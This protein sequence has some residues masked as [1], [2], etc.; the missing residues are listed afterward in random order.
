MI[1]NKAKTIFFI[2]KPLSDILHII[3]L[4]IYIQQGGTKLNKVE[5]A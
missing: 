5:I 2:R 1:K 4:T 3:P